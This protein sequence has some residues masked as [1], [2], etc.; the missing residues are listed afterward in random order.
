MDFPRPEFSPIRDIDRLQFPV[1]P[2]YKIDLSPLLPVI[3]AVAGPSQ[4]LKY[5]IL[6]ESFLIM[7]QRKGDGI[8]DAVVERIYFFGID[9]LDL[10]RVGKDGDKADQPFFLKVGDI[11]EDRFS[12][13]M[14][15]RLNAK[16]IGIY[17][18][19]GADMQDKVLEKLLEEVDIPDGEL[20]DQVFID[21]H[22]IMVFKNPELEGG[23]RENN[24]WVSF[25]DD[26]FFKEVS[27]LEADV[28]IGKIRSQVQTLK[29]QELFESQG[30]K[31]KVESTAGKR[32]RQ[33]PS[34]EPGR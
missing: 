30:R 8:A 34:T 22:V 11:V 12:G 28:G 25:I 26:V 29:G 24:L 14:Q 19:G 6:D 2:C 7:R 16:E 33:R 9:L 4:L 3:H 5:Q 27:N 31:G 21:E 17:G 1:F 32:R 10:R 23:V 18:K 20:V 15:L 13:D